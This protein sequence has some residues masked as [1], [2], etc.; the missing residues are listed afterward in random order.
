MNE[1][2]SSSTIL[3]E[4]S[5]GLARQG[6]S[7]T[8]KVRCTRELEIIL[9]RL[10]SREYRQSNFLPR[11]VLTITERTDEMFKELRFLWSV[12]AVWKELLQEIGIHRVKSALDIGCGFFPKAELGFY[13]LN[14]T[15]KLTLLDCSAEALR[16]AAHFLK[17]FNVGFSVERV[18]VSLWDLPD[19]RYDLIVAN[20]SLDDLI[21]DAAARECG[22][23]LID[24]YRSEALFQELWQSIIKDSS[25][26]AEVMDRLAEFIAGHLNPGGRVVLLDYPSR[27]HRALGLNSIPRYVGARQKDLRACLEG[28]GFKQQPLLKGG[29][30]CRERLVV[31][32]NHVVC[33]V[34]PR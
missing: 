19:H 8:E 11:N 12:G 24:A 7:K 25:L 16:Q 34:A 15:G 29:S 17:F 4:L 23:S 18:P 33:A 3:E 30:I 31:S 14:F 32:A 26:G 22:V 21:L 13:Y 9:G 27:S 5:N 2:I 20:H 10:K 6:I 28:K 1:T